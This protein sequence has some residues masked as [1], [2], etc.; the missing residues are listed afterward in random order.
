MNLLGGKLRIYAND[1]YIGDEKKGQ[2]LEFP[3]EEDCTI[4]AKCGI[5]PNKGKI[6]AKAGKTT[7][8]KYEYNRLTGNFIPT[9]VDTVVNVNNNY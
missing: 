5:N 1:K 2:N 4:T 9:I 6:E 3:I 7:R 8:I